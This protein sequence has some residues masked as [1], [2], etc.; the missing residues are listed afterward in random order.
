MSQSIRYSKLNS[1]MESS[2]P[3]LRLSLE[4]LQLIAL[5][6]AIQHAQYLAGLKGDLDSQCDGQCDDNLACRL[7]ATKKRKLLCDGHA[8]TVVAKLSPALVS[9]NLHVF[10][11]EYS[12]NGAWLWNSWILAFSSTCRQLRSMIM[13]GVLL[14]TLKLKGT[15]VAELKKAITL[16]GSSPITR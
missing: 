10:D 9:A 4:V 16:F 13:Q 2:P 7:G 5:E 8:H 1:R 12:D 15:S 14:E 6:V 3:V 11:V